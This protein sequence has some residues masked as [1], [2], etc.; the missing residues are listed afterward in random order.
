MTLANDLAQIGGNACGSFS[1]SEGVTR[2][3]LS[4]PLAIP[5]ILKRM[6]WFLD[7]TRRVE[8]LP[9]HGALLHTGASFC[10]VATT[11]TVSLG[12][13][14]VSLGGQTTLHRAVTRGGGHSPLGDNQRIAHNG[15]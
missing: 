9:R 7:M 2:V 15:S 14:A 11:P 4:T 3:V 6:A 12:A 5:R 8:K 10:F 13:G 1:E